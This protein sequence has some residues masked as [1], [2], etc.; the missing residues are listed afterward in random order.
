[1]R[2]RRAAS[3]FVGPWIEP[4][5][6]AVYT[7]DDSLSKGPT[8]IELEGDDLY[9]L[10][11]QDMSEKLCEAIDDQCKAEDTKRSRRK[12]VREWAELRSSIA[13]PGHRGRVAGR[14]SCRSREVP[15]L[16]LVISL[17][18]CCSTIELYPLNLCRRRQWL[19]LFRV[20]G[21]GDD[22]EEN[23]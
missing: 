5:K 22:H 2:L 12:T 1:M 16:F 10:E 6:R 15:D 17:E 19:V 20:R 9:A 7:D 18:G 3:S 11:T 4:E 23:Y 21:A 13:V 14:T 8:W